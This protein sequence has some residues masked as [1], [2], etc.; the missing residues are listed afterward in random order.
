MNVEGWVK[1]NRKIVSWEWYQDSQMVHL[2]LHLIL[3]ANSHDGSWKGIDIKR[4]QLI[5][6]RKK[7]AE[8]TGISE[9]S[10][11]TCL[12]RLKKTQ[13]LTIKS[14]NK[15]SLITI[16]NYDEYQ[17]QEKHTNQQTNQQLTSNQ[18]ATNQQLTTYNNNKNIKK[19]KNKEVKN[20][21]KIHL[22]V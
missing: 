11:R 16:L 21:T 17:T 8:I 10:L 3:S 5:T 7:L 13:E 20:I 6:G 22:K 1:L 12:S 9:Q 14:T 4:G 15:Y 19:E 18:P 2:F